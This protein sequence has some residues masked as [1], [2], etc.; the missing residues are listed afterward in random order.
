MRR[1]P[2]EHGGI[3]TARTVAAQARNLAVVF[4]ILHAVEK[5]RCTKGLPRGDAGEFGTAPVP[6]G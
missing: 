1:E 6:R 3:G 2:P 5:L 4:T